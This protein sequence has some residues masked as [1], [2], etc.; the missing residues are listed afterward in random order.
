MSATMKYALNRALLAAVLYV[1]VA[2]SAWAG[3]DEGL[4]AYKRGDY[5]T[6]LKEWFSV[7]E[8]GD[9][10]SQY[11]L[12]VM[13]ENGEGVPR[14][15][16]EAVKWYREAAQQGLAAAQYSLGLSYATGLGVQQDDAE[17]EKWFR[18]A[19]GLSK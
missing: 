3:F 13:Y 4:A 12:A 1:V 16:V 19:A 7:A 14:D 5:A 9:A 18:E 11:Y 17:A 15:Y 2:T 10:N 8:Q 6:A